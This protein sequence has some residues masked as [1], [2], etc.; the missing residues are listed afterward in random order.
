M[1]ILF[2]VLLILFGFILIMADILFIPGGIVGIVGG[3]FILSAIVA[4]YKTLGQETA[5]LLGGGSV[6]L[7][8]ILAYLSVKFR[9]WRSFV[10]S[11]DE[12]KSG[13]FSSFKQP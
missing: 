13:G 2:A 4:A 1:S 6:I 5:F 11:D 3:L 10:R 8:G 7:A 9:V 12:K